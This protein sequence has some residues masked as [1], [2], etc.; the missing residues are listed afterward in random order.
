VNA[1]NIPVVMDVQPFV[2][3]IAIAVGIMGGNYFIKRGR[4]PLMFVTALGWCFIVGA[5]LLSIVGLVSFAPDEKLGVIALGVI[6]ASVGSFF[7]LLS[8]F[9]DHRQPR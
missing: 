6:L 7:L 9:L 8:R 2:G 4:N 5:F 3:P 1:A